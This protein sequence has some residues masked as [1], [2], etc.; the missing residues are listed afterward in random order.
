L[1][2]LL[3]EAF[4]SLGGGE[5]FLREERVPAGTAQA[6]QYSSVARMQWQRQ[7]D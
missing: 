3:K 4:H 5:S 6:L 1:R 2:G 7:R